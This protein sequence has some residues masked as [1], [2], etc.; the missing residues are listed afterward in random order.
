MDRDG[1][2]WAH[3]VRRSLSLAVGM[4]QTPGAVPVPAG[5]F[6]SGQSGGSGCHALQ[7]SSRTS[8]HGHGR[9]G[10]IVGD[11]EEGSARVL[12]A[13]LIPSLGGKRATRDCRYPPRSSSSFEGTCD[14][15]SGLVTRYS[16]VRDALRTL[17]SA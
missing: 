7:S 13:V 1:R 4:R 16:K 5:L 6:Q 12:C 14:G 8:D 10:S 2:R 9:S 3:S 15:S 17:K 11:S